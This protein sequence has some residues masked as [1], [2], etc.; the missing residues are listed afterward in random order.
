MI[1][2]YGIGSRLRVLTLAISRGEPIEWQINEH[3]STPFL[4]VFPDGING[5][6]VTEVHGGPTIGYF[7]TAGDSMQPF[8]H[9]WESLKLT[10]Y[11]STSLGLH[12][13]GHW[14]PAMS[15]PFEHFK[16]F[17]ETA[18]EFQHNLIPLVADSMRA[19]IMALSPLIQ[20]PE[21][22][23]MADDMDRPADQTRRYLADLA[24]ILPAER[25]IT[26]VEQSSITWLHDA[27]RKAFDV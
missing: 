14:I 16:I 5:L 3:C 8:R 22:A 11:P 18:L 9:V 6:D 20:A 13:R 12:Y 4:E 7:P 15:R 17:V 19:E 25:I 23:E 2:S 27:Y 1:A 26:N 21:S 10:R 24:H